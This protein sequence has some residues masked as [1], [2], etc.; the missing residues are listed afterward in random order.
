MQYIQTD[1]YI[2]NQICFE[3]IMLIVLV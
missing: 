3:P 2:C 1:I